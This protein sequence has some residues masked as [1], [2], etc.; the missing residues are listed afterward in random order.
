MYNRK[1]DPMKFTL[2]FLLG[3]TLLNFSCLS[4]HILINFNYLKNHGGYYAKY[5]S[6]IYHDVVDIVTRKICSG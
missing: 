6:D 4:N 1:P 3:I 5:I 2:K